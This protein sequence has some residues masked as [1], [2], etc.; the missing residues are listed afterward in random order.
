MG[1]GD[2]RGSRG[3]DN[4]EIY[5]KMVDGSNPLRLTTDPALDQAPRWSP[6]GRYVAFIRQ[7]SIFVVPP[8]GGTERKLTDTTSP[9]ET[10][11]AGSQGDVAWTP[12]SQSIA[13]MDA[14]GAIVLFNLQTG[15]R[16]QLTH[17][18]P[19]SGGDRFFA[20]SPD[21]SALAFARWTTSIGAGQLYV[22]P[23]SGGPLKR[24]EL[25]NNFLY[26][27]AWA[28]DGEAIVAAI[29][30]GGPTALWRVPINSGQPSRI[31]GFED[32]ARQP[33]VSIASHRLVYARTIADENIWTA[34]GDS[35]TQLIAS[36]RR[37][38]NPQFS[39]DGGKIAFVSDR[40][41]GW[42]IY[43]SDAQGGQVVQLTSFGSVVADGV[44]W[45]PDGRE[46]V[47][48]VLEGTNRDIYTVSADGGIT[49]RITRE[50]SD[51][52]RPSYSMNGKWIYFRSN[53]SGNDEIWRL[54]RGGGHAVQVTQGGG[55]EATETLD[56]KD[57]YFIRAR[58]ESGLWRMT[59]PDGA[60]RAVPGLES[61]WQG[62]WGVTQ[63]GVCFLPQSKLQAPIPVS[64]GTPRQ[65]SP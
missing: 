4:F 29:Q 64:V 60:A 18:P 8:L 10:P 65:E 42:E 6:D 55:F 30:L 58:A 1:L 59:S 9:H 56:G 38:F 47:F 51:E 43:V 44:R 53:R 17:P 41:G 52:G 50:V 28:P 40:T 61:A 13:F 45:S 39:P 12:D 16:R 62:R 24:I 57:L 32:G 46:L 2:G 23:M 33:A 48:A 31:P 15:D 49:K 54:P 7:Q 35:R 11:I 3:R 22:L 26:E 63:D 37:D 25:P 14:S 19:T 27:V 20:F 5:V 34:T 36:T 21:G